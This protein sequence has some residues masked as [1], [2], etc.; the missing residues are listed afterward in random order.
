MRRTAL[1]VMADLMVEDVVAKNA[2]GIGCELSSAAKNAYEQLQ[3][4]MKTVC[5]VVK[6]LFQ[7]LLEAAGGCWSNLARMLARVCML[8]LVAHAII[9]ARLQSS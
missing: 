9:L 6:V 7:R 2:S 4:A 1:P 8:S 5:M 3:I